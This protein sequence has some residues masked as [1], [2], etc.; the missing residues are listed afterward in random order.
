MN[1]IVHIGPCGYALLAPI[2]LASAAIVQ[3][4]SHSHGWKIIWAQI[5]MTLQLVLMGF[6]L[7]AIFD[8][9]HPLVSIL[10]IT[11]MEIFAAITVVNEHRRTVPKAVLRY[12]ALGLVGGSLIACAL[13]IY[14]VVGI[15]P[16]VNPRYLLPL[17]GMIVGNS[18][19]AMNL[20]I[21]SMHTQ[22]CAQATMITSAVLLGARKSDAVA[23]VARE[24]FLASLTPTITTMF[25]L[26]IVVLP[27]MMTGQ[28][29]SGSLPL[30]AVAYQLA[31]MVAILF[32]VVL[33]TL[34]ALTRGGRHFLNHIPD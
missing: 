28:I 33:S 27:G 9:P 34:F 4:F 23:P 8:H 6:I 19:T 5:R 22:I 1:T 24:A 32:S 25:S 16:L 15:N 7:V 21:R 30:V 18:M 14:G 29:L 13:F 17:L 10:A 12:A 11:V 31:I 26:G 3:Y 20:A 2:G